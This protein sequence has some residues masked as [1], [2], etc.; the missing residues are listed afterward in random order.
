MILPSVKQCLV[1]ALMRKSPK[2]GS[3][4][5]FRSTKPLAVA[6]IWP[7]GCDCD[8]DGSSFATLI[9]VLLKMGGLSNKA[10]R[11]E[12]KRNHRLGSSAPSVCYLDAKSP[13]WEV[14][15]L[16]VADASPAKDISKT[17]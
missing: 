1:F 3:C 9:W 7:C 16:R 10:D 13:C 17:L 14:D 8:S 4:M 15:R 5:G 6:V 11:H 2:K 12:E